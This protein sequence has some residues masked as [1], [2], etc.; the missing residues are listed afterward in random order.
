MTGRIKIIVTD[1]QISYREGISAVLKQAGIDTVGQAENGKE[2]MHL[3]QTKKIKADVIL[4]DIDMPV[5]DGCEALVK[6]KEF[7]PAQKVVMLS[8]YDNASLIND[9]KAKGA[10]SFL[11]KN[12]PSSEIADTIRRVFYFAEYSNIPKQIRST[13]TKVEIEIMRLLLAGKKS[14]EIAKIRGTSLQSVEAHRKKMYEKTDSTNVTDFTRY[15]TKEGLI[16]LGRGH[17]KV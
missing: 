3:L 6:I 13:F 5:M 10:S 15:C 12:T 14:H 11:K 7:D 8:L 16:F 2:L 1:D 17:Q 9:L 4:L